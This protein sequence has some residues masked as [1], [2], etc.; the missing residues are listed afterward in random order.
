MRGVARGFEQS[1]NSDAD[2]N[3]G[4]PK[5]TILRGLLTIAALHGNQVAFGYCHSAFHQSPMPG[6]SEPVYVEPAPEAQ[7]DSS[8][9]WLCKKAFQGLKIF[10]QAWGTHSTQKINDMSYNHLISDPS[11]YVKKRTQRSGDA[12]LLR[13]MDDVVGTGPD[14]HL[15]SDFEHMKT[16]L[17]LTDVVV[18]RHEGDTFNCF[19]LEITK[20][21]RSFEVKN[22]TDFV[23]SLMNLYGLENSKPTA[24]LGRRST[25]MELASAIPLDCHDYSKF[26][27]AA[28]KLIFMAP[29]RPDMQFAT[30]QLPTQVLNPTSQSKR[31]VKQLIRYLEGA[32]WFKRVCWNLLIIVTQIGPA[33][34]Q[35]AKALRDIIAMYRT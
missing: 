35:C 9:A 22:S 5:L 28:G 1:V 2:F 7:L 24:N 30:Q 3:A 32:E 27:T 8:K 12:I 6:D 23:E 4:T 14:E 34:Q 15:M 16:S 21:S 13:H 10:P 26:R 31:A 17:Y 20:T 11:T 33:T 18:L 29:W 19:G 25:V